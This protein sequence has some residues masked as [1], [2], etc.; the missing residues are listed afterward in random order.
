MPQLQISEAEKE[1]LQQ[2][3]S[4][5]IL[6]LNQLRE[7]ALELEKHMGKQKREIGNKQKEI[8]DL[9]SFID[10]VDPKDPRYVSKV[11]KSKYGN[12]VFLCQVLY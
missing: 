5:K 12:L 11:L 7:E 3:L 8:E 10:S 1:S 9:Q 4:G 6:L 2:Q